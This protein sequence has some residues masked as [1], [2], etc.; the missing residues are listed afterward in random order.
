VISR[1][2]GAVGGAPSD[3]PLR[4]ILGS[5][6]RA[7]DATVPSV[8]FVVVWLAGA[9]LGVA[10]PILAGGVAAVL[11]SAAVALWRMRHGERPRAVAVGLF[12]AVV[13]AVIALY[14]GDARDFFLPR[15]AANAGSLVAWLLSIA[16]RWPLLGL[17]VG[18]ATGKPTAWHADPDL[19]RAYSRASW[20]WAGQYVVRL[21]VF[22]PLWGADQ[23]VALGIAQ[24]VL[25]WPLVVVCVLVSWPLMRS[26]LPAGHPGIRH[27]V[28]GGLRGEGPAAA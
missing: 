13:A 11:V 20:A 18:A 16:V 26:A 7:V 19:V 5:W 15:I 6:G 12:V 27:P 17:V 21:L 24:V 23:V 9:P 1:R 10:Q 4:A 22:L 2:D 3:D 8:A 28:P 14:T 25:T